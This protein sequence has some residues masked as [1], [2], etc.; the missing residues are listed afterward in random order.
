MT[1]LYVLADTCFPNCHAAGTSSSSV[2]G[3]GGV[4]LA[5][6]F[7]LVIARIMIAKGSKG[8]GK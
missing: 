3:N 1:H 4:I 2:T 8:G 5:I 6:I 7:I